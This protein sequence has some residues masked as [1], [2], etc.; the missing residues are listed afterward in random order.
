MNTARS[1]NAGAGATNTA[2]LSIGG[3]SPSIVAIVESWDGSSWTEI[4]DCNT[5]RIG[6]GAFGT[7]ANAITYG[8]ETPSMTV[9]TEEWDGSAWT[10]V[11]NLATAR[12]GIGSS[13]AT[14]QLGVAAGGNPAAAN[15]TNHAEEW[16]Q[17][18]N[19]KTITD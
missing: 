6:H 10:E 12:Q 5:S 15:T 14:A 19:V 8:G 11:A 13:G 18:Q 4:A 2:A 9:N 3:S 7:Q 1:H 16:T 17:A